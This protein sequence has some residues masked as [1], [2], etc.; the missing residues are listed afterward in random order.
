MWG[1]KLEGLLSEPALLNQKVTA[2]LACKH[3]NWGCKL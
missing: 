2:L 1:I 3:P